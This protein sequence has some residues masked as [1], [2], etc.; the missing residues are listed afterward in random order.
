M[1]EWMRDDRKSPNVLTDADFV[2]SM[3]YLIPRPPEPGTCLP[4]V[5]QSNLYGTEPTEDKFDQSDARDFLKIALRV[6]RVSPE[7]RIGLL[8]QNDAPA[9]IRRIPTSVDCSYAEALV[10]LDSGEW[11]QVICDET[12]EST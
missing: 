11:R 2:Q 10:C 9:A 7:I 6:A 1:E 5:A 12:P 4:V 3:G 8:N